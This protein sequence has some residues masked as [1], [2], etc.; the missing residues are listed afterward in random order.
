LFIVVKLKVFRNKKQP[1]T[2][3]AQAKPKTLALLAHAIQIGRPF[4]KITSATLNPEI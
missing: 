3:Q 2:L 4:M 1:L